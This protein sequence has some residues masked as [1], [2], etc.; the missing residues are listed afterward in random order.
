VRPFADQ[1]LLDDRAIDAPIIDNQAMEAQKSP[2][3]SEGRG[4][5]GRCRFS[6]T[7]VVQ[8][9]TRGSTGRPPF[10]QPHLRQRAVERF[11]LA[12]LV[13]RSIRGSNFDDPTLNGHAS[14][15]SLPYPELL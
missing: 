5:G 15:L 4:S 1:H 2:R 11:R 6:W 3:S 7:D 8:A 13:R 12:L 10:S 14:V 9:S